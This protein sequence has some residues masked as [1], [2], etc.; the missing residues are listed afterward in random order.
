MRSPLKLSLMTLG[1]FCALAV[2]AAYAAAP[3]TAPAPAKTATPAKPSSP[4]A[5]P[6]PKPS[7]VPAIPPDYGGRD[8]A[9]LAVSASAPNPMAQAGRA[10]EA[11]TI[12]LAGIVGVIYG[13]KRF[14]L[15]T[16]GVDGKPGRIALPP[17]GRL[18]SPAPPASS[19]IT[20]VSSQALPGGAMLHVVTVA[21][22]TLLLAA[23]GHTV[24]TVAE[25]A[26]QPKT[27]DEATAF[28]DFLT[29]AD[30]E[31]VSGIAAANAR[32]RSLLSSAGERA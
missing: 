28:E 4:P 2:S 10:L 31:P 32:L 16:P 23:T 22:R 24:T 18:L 26:E 5:K 13:L 1:L 11:L 9:P 14:G 8:N 19:P 30:P 15:V 27:A 17:L 20:V 6:A 29:R 3:T 7:P 21:G 25:W 12:V